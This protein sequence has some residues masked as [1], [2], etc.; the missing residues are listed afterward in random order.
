MV[1]GMSSTLLINADAPVTLV[2]EQLRGG[3]SALDLVG[4]DRRD[5][6]VVAPGVE[7]RHGRVAELGRDVDDPVVHRGVEEPVDLPL[8]ERLDLGALG[9][10]VA[11]AVDEHQ[12]PAALGGGLLGSEDDLPGVGVV[13]I[14]SL[15]MARMCERW[16]RRLRA[17]PLAR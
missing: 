8:L 11:A 9:L 16:S 7:Q 12:Q 17:I 15:T 13:A 5:A 14:W 3:L 1:A 6:R 10:P 4:S 2:E